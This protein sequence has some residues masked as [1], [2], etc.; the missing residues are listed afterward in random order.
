MEID[1][2][3]V[4]EEDELEGFKWK[5]ISPK[6]EYANSIPKKYFN[7]YRVEDCGI[8]IHKQKLDGD[9]FDTTRY[10]YISEEEGITVEEEVIAV[11]YIL[12][13]KEIRKYMSENFSNYVNNNK[14]LPFGCSIK[15]FVENKNKFIILYSPIGEQYS[16]FQFSVSNDKLNIDIS[17]LESEFDNRLGYIR[18]TEDTIEPITR[19]QFSNYTKVNVII[20][21]ITEINLR[22]SRYLDNITYFYILKLS[23][24]KLD[25]DHIY[26]EI[27]IRCTTKSKDKYELNIGDFISFKG[28]IKTDNKLGVLIQ[29]IR[30]FTKVR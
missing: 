17:N 13:G 21:K 14:K 4:N 30:K 5:Y 20:S 24:I 18:K 15:K 1:I 29:N 11:S 6:F 19:T 2:E 25:D 22:E 26:E 12:D 10:H 23:N 27:N 16:T 9:R 7:N 28:S 3:K 8:L